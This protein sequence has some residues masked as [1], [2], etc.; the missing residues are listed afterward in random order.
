MA[1]SRPRRLERRMDTRQSQT[2]SV[3]FHL[4]KPCNLRCRFCFATFRDIEGHLSAD[5]AIRLVRALREAGCEKLTF[6]GAEPTLCPHLGA[7]LAEARR[8]GLVT[9]IVTNGA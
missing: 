1:P 5:D 2:I 4:W 7:L 8:V 6:A 3:N 9:C